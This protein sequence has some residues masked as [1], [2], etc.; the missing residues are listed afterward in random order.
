MQSFCYPMY[1][2]HCLKIIN[3]MLTIDS[4][5]TCNIV[6]CG[7]SEETLYRI[8][9]TINVTNKEMY[10]CLL[11]Y[12]YTVRNY[13]I[14]P[15]QIYFNHLWVTNILIYHNL[16]CIPRTIPTSDEGESY[17]KLLLCNILPFATVYSQYAG[18]LL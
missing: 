1:M 18:S 3:T 11:T 12:I 9:H 10:S 2:C 16:H 6:Y 14:L 7:I 5:C 4:S 13:L 8:V 15:L 17:L